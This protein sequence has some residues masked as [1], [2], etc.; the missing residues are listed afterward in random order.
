MS[1][2][3][4]RSRVALVM[5]MMLASCGFSPAY[6]PSGAARDLQGAIS[7]QPPQT[8]DAFDF[9]THLERRLGR[10]ELSRYVLSYEITVS[11]ERMAISANNITTRFN[12]I[13]KATYGLKGVASEKT[14][15]TGRVQSFT[16]YSA[17]GSTAATQAAR[18]DA[19]N[20]LMRILA[21]QVIAI[22][23][24]KSGGFAE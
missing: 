11:E 12:V 2:I 6:G 18:R 15:I 3:D 9:V 10:S 4:W 24:A 14:L 8:R 22:L 17:T 23:V 20:R 1:W 19:H 21:D 7:F 16:G 5:F 13:G